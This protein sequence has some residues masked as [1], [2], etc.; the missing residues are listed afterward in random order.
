[1]SF[2]RR[3]LG[4]RPGSP[5]RSPAGDVPDETRTGIGREDVEGEEPQGEEAER[6]RALLREDAD[7]LSGELIARQLRFADRKW[8]PPAQGGARRAEDGDAAAGD[9]R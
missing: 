1:M 8:T 9:R 6:D 4:G 7:R 5:D 2:L 3:V